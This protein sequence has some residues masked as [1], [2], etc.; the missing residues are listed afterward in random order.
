MSTIYLGNNLLSSGGGVKSYANIAALVA[1]ASPV[2]GDLALVQ[3][4]NKIFVYNGTGWFLIATVTNETPSSI[5]GV[6]GNYILSTEGIPTTITAIATDPEGFPLTW[7]YAVT[8]GSLGAT[9]TVEQTENVFIIT[10]LQ[11]EGNF[12]ISFSATD[13]INTPTTFVSTFSLSFLS[14]YGIA[15][16]GILGMGTSSL[17]GIA[18]S[19]SGDSVFLVGY[20]GGQNIYKWNLTTN[21]KLDTILPSGA[22][23]VTPTQTLPMPENVPIG[24]WMSTNS[25]K[26][27]TGAG[28]RMYLFG[29]GGAYTAI[30]NTPYDFSSNPGWNARQTFADGIHRFGLIFGATV[31]NSA[32]RFYLSCTTTPGLI[33][34][35]IFNNYDLLQCGQEGSWRAHTDYVY[36]MCFNNAENRFLTGDGYG[37]I[38]EYSCA[39]DARGPNILNGNSSFLGDINLSSALI[40]TYDL[41]TS[42]GLAGGEVRGLQFSADDTRLYVALRGAGIVELLLNTPGTILDGFV[43]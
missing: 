29:Y 6:N 38:R 21:F 10:P 13:N 12:T 22:V 17:S 23:E 33:Y 7:S 5:S 4:A 34:Q 42:S 9:A 41:T 43:I 31:S 36:G 32:D 14:S 11:T 26:D 30:L 39:S 20:S 35:W 15:G 37:N 8:S 40:N 1:V 19:E 27:P 24:Y 25:T 3:N 18:V 16:G 2:S 28:K